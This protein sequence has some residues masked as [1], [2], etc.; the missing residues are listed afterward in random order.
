M[1]KV[2]FGIFLALLFSGCFA[3]ANSPVRGFIATSTTAPIIDTG[4]ESS[5]DIKTG[6]STCI[7]IL[8]LIAAGDCSIDKAKKDGNISKVISVEYESFSVLGIY[9]SYTTIVK[10]EGSDS[11]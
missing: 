3:G 5:G 9:A 2:M 1:V 10:G 6:K 4:L 8:G 11:K 7:S